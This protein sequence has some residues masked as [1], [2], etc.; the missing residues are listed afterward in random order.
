MID[1]IGSVYAFSQGWPKGPLPGI[2]LQPDLLASDAFRSLNR[3]GLRV[4]LRFMQKRQIPKKGSQKG[5]IVNN[6]HI[7][8]PYT[9]AV[10]MGISKS[11]FTRS[12]DNLI[13]FGFVDITF[14]GKGMSKSQTQYAISTRWK[15]WGKIDFQQAERPKPKR[16]PQG[17]LVQNGKS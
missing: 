7:K 15:R 14:S 9:E 16:K 13:E 5:K 6:G 4:L 1:R 11:A 17:F 2:Y 3:N 8:F 10:A 12:L